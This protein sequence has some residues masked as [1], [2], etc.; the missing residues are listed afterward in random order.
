MTERFSV[1][2]IVDGDRLYYKVHDIEND[3][4]IECGVGELNNTIW[5]LLGV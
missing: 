3:K 5:K 1:S 2:T 4:I